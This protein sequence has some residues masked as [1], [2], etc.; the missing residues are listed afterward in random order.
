MSTFICVLMRL[1]LCLWVFEP[2]AARVLLFLQFLIFLIIFP[3]N[4]KAIKPFLEAIGS[5]HRLQSW[6][7]AHKSFLTRVGNHWEILLEH[8]LE[9]TALPCGGFRKHMRKGFTSPMVS[10]FPMIQILGPPIHLV[11]ANEGSFCEKDLREELW[12]VVIFLIFMV[13]VRLIIN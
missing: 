6:S 11:V 2:S 5:A 9:A 10:F 1:I 13:R 3:A 12:L 7:G 8:V 4:M